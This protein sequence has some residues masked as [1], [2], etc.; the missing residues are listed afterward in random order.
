VRGL[1][2]RRRVSSPYEDPLATLQRDSFG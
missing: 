1:G 2:V